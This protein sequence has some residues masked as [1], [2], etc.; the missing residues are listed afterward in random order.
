MGELGEVGQSAQTSSYKINSG[1]IM[2]NMKTRVY[3]T[4]LY[5][6]KVAEK[7]DVIKVLITRKTTNY[8]R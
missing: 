6:L 2:Y 3:N 1:D 4:I 7:V 8:V 5:C